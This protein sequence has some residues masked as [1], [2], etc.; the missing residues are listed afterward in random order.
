[1]RTCGGAGGVTDGAACGGVR[2]AVP[3]CQLLRR[4]CGLVGAVDG[5]GAAVVGAAVFGVTALGATAVFGF[6]PRCG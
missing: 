4:I 2:F 5:V 6:T 1:V 3:P